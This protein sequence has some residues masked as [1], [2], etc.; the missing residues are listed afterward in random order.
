MRTWKRFAAGLVA[1]AAFA[2]PGA[3]SADHGCNGEVTTVG[4]DE[5][6]VL[7]V[8]DRGGG[9]LWVYAETNMEA[10]L[11]SGGNQPVL[12]YSDDCQHDNPDLLLY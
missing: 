9:S 8:D 3:A 1:I 4:T 6:G 10:G 5:G 2:V 11:Q 12:E 7:Y